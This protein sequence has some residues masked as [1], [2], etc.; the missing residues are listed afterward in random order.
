MNLALAI[1]S[2]FAALGSAAAAFLA[3][4]TAEK[5]NDTSQRMEAIERDRR[6]AELAPQFGVFCYTQETAHEYAF[7]HVVL[8]EGGVD[9]LDEVIIRILDEAWTDHW[10]REL[11]D[12]VSQKEA[13]GFVWGPWE[14]NADAS[15]QVVNNRIS[16]PRRYSRADG[17]NWDILELRLTR[18]G[19]WM[20]MSIENWQKR[21]NNEPIR[22]SIACRRKGYEAWT[23]HHEVKP[24][25]GPATT[26]RVRRQRL[27][28]G[29]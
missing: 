25:T 23:V 9:F 22:L 28:S 17:K 1:I 19:R 13:E 7:L 21:Q 27:T 24:D 4:R 2:V 20:S 8:E 16:R 15:G 6:H 18:P 29:F 10:G 26:K 12:G 11:P 14:F 3:W 5:A